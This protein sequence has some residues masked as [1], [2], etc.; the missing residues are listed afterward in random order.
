MV[1]FPKKQFSEDLPDREIHELDRM[2]LSFSIPFL[3]N[4]SR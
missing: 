4:C 1:L 2:L 3:V